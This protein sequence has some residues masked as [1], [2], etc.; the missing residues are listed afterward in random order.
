MRPEFAEA[1][2]PIFCYVLDLLERIDRGEAISAETV[3]AAVNDRFKLAE[4]N[5]PDMDSWQAARHALVYWIDEMLVTVPWAGREHWKGNGSLGWKYFNTNTREFDFFVEARKTRE[6]DLQD[7]LEVYYTCVALGFRGIYAN[8]GQASV[9]ARQQSL[10]ANL[11]MWARET[12]VAIPRGQRLPPIHW[13]NLQEID[14]A[15]PLTARQSLFWSGVT[16]IVLILLILAVSATRL[17]QCGGGFEFW[18][19]W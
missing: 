2:D 10:P 13:R 6:Q 7:A 19:T 5:T 14:G 8:T 12:A 18:N 1:V 15:P 11:E 4:S 17:G 16:A 9:L 3:R